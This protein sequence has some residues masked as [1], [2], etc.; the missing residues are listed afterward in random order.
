M[1]PTKPIHNTDTTRETL[2]QH[3]ILDITGK[4]EPRSPRGQTRN[5]RSFMRGLCELLFVVSGAIAAIVIAAMSTGGNAVGF[6]QPPPALQIDT[7]S[8]AVRQYGPKILG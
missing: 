3:I 5:S 1:L 8:H 6:Y 7:E 2:T 4:G